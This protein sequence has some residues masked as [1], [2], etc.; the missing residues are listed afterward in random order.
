MEA[1]VGRIGSALGPLL[2][3]PFVLFGHS[4]GG[5][6][7]FELARLLRRSG[8]RSPAR[9]IVSGCAA[10]RRV[11]SCSPG[12]PY[13]EQ[14]LVDYLH[15]AGAAPRAV[16]R[17]KDLLRLLLPALRADLTLF[18][19]YR[20]AAEPPLECAISVLAGRQDRLVNEELL[21]GWESETIGPFSLQMLP[22]GH[23][24]PSSHEDAF[25]RVLRRE[26]HE[27]LQGVDERAAAREGNASGRS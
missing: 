6:I 9:L 3:R 15:R 20:Y 13:R 22:G 16:L 18:D 27:A 12:R 7:A 17:E 14:E 23:F 21:G 19:T 11:E 10:P 24:F 26:L 5:L 1:L 25:L 2:D 8:R 4:L